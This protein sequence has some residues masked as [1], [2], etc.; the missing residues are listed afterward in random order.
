[1]RRT[2]HFIPYDQKSALATPNKNFMVC[3][4][5]PSRGASEI[6]VIRQRQAAGGFNPWHTHNVE[7]V[8]VLLSGSVSV[9]AGSER[10][11]MGPGDTLIV[12]PKTAHRIENTSEQDAE[13]LIISRADV[14]FFRED[15][16]E[17]MPP[18][19]R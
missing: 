8:M 15:G 13:W 7:E 16:E 18:W 11:S 3:L 10:F 1:M 9:S 6:S 2:L 17:V 12:P 4:S 5:T 14:K 19:A